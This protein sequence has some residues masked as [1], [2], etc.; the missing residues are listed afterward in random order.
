MYIKMFYGATFV[1]T[2]GRIAHT[3]HHCQPS[4]V[5]TVTNIK[6]VCACV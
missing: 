6:D 1:A 3:L 4:D 5:L 2:T